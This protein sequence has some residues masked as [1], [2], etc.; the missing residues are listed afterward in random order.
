MWKLVGESESPTATTSSSAREIERI[1][2]AINRAS[3]RVTHA[4]C[5]TRGLAAVVLLRLA[6]LPYHMIV[7][8]HKSAAGDFS[9]HAWVVSQGQVVTGNLPDLANYTPLPIGS[10]IPPLR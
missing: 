10:A 4:T 1:S 5:L 3:A 2:R 8:V 7:G 6:G 9:A